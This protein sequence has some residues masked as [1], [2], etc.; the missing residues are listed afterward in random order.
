MRGKASMTYLNASFWEVEALLHH[1]GE[2]TDTTSLFSKDV[3]R[4]SSQDDDFSPGWGHTDLNT[5]VAILGELSHE[6]LVQLRL[7]HPI[8]YELW[9]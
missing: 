4:A 2:F 5:T 8:S 9:I 7:E 3:L 1:S 6:K